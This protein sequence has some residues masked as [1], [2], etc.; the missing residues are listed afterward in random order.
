VFDERISAKQDSIISE[1]NKHIIS[2]QGRLAARSLS[3][4]QFADIAQR[5]KP[6][7][8]QTF[9]VIPYWKDKESKDIG[10][11]I[12]NALASAGWTLENP[13]RYTMIAGVLAGVV[14]NIDKRASDKVQ[15]A[16]RELVRSLNDNGIAAEIDEH[17][18]T[19]TQTPSQRIDLSVGIKP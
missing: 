12:A 8:P 16:A 1:Q 7:S 6:F 10:D 9:Q 3:D 4:D 14:V 19:T 17:E 2:L 13:V 11:R 5:L 18:D 15:N